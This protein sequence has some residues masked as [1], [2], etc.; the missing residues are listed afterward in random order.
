MPELGASIV[1]VTGAAAGMGAAIARRLAREAHALLLCDLDENKLRANWQPVEQAGPVE[2][3]GGDISDP[4]FGKRLIEAI[5]GRSV[6]VLIHCAGI[7]ATMAKPARILEVNL[8]ATLAL[9][10]T[11]RSR[12]ATGGSVVLFSSS[13]GHY[14]GTAHDA[15]IHS[16]TAP[17]EVAKLIEHAPTPQRAYS[18]SKRAIQLLVRREA[19]SFGRGGVRI[20]SISPGM[21]DTAMGRAEEQAEPLIPAIIAGG[22]LPRRGRPEEVAEVAA[23]LISPG[24]SF[25]TGCDIQVD[26]GQIAA[27]QLSQARAK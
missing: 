19:A 3:F 7:S 6:M 22:A 20:V 12:M 8:T 14:V 18:I 25:I 9:I 24:A 23:F 27:F 21:I 1:I 26:G 13:G 2:F 11:V 16:V 10:E 4:R 15:L 17:G 5:K